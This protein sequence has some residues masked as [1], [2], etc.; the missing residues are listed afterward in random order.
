MS[1]SQ[2]ELSK[3]FFDTTLPARLEKFDALLKGPFFLG[4]KV[5]Y[6][7]ARGGGTPRKIWLGIVRPAS[8]NRYPIYDQNLRFSLYDLT[9][10]SLGKGFCFWLYLACIVG[11]KR[12][13]GRQSADGR[14]RA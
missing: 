13:R 12:G 9:L 10:R 14:W 11:V 7:T 4:D 2:E 3:E 1:V 6:K 5:R 8:Q